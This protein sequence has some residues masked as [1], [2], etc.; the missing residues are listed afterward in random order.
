MWNILEELDVDENCLYG[1]INRRTFPTL[2]ILK[3]QSNLEIKKKGWERDTETER[4]GE[5]GGRE[6]GRILF[7]ENDAV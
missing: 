4:G 3:Q 6:R 7:L 5:R 2:V 1:A